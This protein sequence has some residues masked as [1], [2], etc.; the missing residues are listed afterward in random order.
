MRH[1]WIEEHA[2]EF[3]VKL[4]CEQLDISRSGFY[5]RKSLSVKKSAWRR[6][7]LVAP[8]RRIHLESKQRYGSPRVT[9]ELRNQGL[10]V[11]E[12]MVARCMKEHE[13]SVKT[14]SSYVPRT[15]Q[16]D[17]SLRPSPNLLSRDFTATRINEKWCADITYVRTNEGWLYLATIKDLY[18]KRIVGW[19]MADHLGVELT[20]GALKMAI[21]HRGD[22]RGVIHHSDRGKQYACMEYRNLLAK[23][24]I[25]QSMSA[26]GDCYDN[27]PA[28]SFFAT[29]KKE[30]VN[31]C[32]FLTRKDAEA[33][34]FEYIEV[35]YNR[36]RLH[37]ALNYVSP[38]QFEVQSFV[39][40][41]P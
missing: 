13:I 22:V 36:K 33:A 17:P 12:K 5:A 21:Q 11:N 9:R 10:K 18:S 41:C 19:A 40:H 30:L 7:Q 24:R 3:P 29:L 1:Q 8:I 23:D 25:R 37:S 20:I 27:A 31:R 34:I 39:T 35:F 38:E 16:N 2:K 14:A 28:E 4:M 26:V 6:D 15:T 32:E